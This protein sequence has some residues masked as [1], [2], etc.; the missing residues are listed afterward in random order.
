MSHQT[1]CKGACLP[2]QSPPKA[3]ANPQS[4]RL[5]PKPQRTQDRDM[6]HDRTRTEKS[7]GEANFCGPRGQVACPWLATCPLPQMCCLSL[8]LSQTSPLLGESHCDHIVR[9]CV[10]PST[11]K[12]T[13]FQKFEM[14]SQSKSSQTRVASMVQMNCASSLIWHSMFYAIIAFYP[15]FAIAG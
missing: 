14:V 6:S 2:F 9:S 10:L 15:V 1:L 7:P 4:E 5:V 13:G 12:T 8:P 11:E 3:Y